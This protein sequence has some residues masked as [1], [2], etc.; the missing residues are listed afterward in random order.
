MGSGGPKGSLSHP[1]GDGAS[2]LNGRVAEQFGRRCL[3]DAVSGS[4]ASD[5]TGLAIQ[6]GSSSDH[7]HNSN[8]SPASAAA[9]L[10]HEE[11]ATSAEGALDADSNG[12]DATAE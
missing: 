3:D 1:P 5:R 11:A 2:L 6:C 4:D 10:R 7:P 9:L 12:S 8:P